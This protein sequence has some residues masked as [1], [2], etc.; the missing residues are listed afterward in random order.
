MRT[1]NGETRSLYNYQTI[2]AFEDMHYDTNVLS[3][4]KS[5]PGA[6]YENLKHNEHL[7]ILEWNI[8]DVASRTRFIGYS[9]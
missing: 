7:P 6:V 9:R 5:L 8:M 3:D 4:Q 1:K 2:G